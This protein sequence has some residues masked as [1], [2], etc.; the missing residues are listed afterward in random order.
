[1]QTIR[2]R[3]IGSS[4]KCE[5]GSLVQSENGALRL[6]FG[7][8]EGTL[9]YRVNSSLT[10]T[11]RVRGG[12]AVIPTRTLAVGVMYPELYTADGNKVVCQPLTIASY[13][14]ANKNRF[15]AC[16][17]ADDYLPRLVDVEAQLEELKSEYANQYKD[18]SEKM[19]E[20]NARLRKISKSYGLGLFGGTEQ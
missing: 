19:D 9:S 15:T 16:P 7:T 2:Y 3:I 11:V 5:T 6:D 12:V 8:V 20:A 14:E 18:L 10:Q 1:M 13:F 17:E 4:A